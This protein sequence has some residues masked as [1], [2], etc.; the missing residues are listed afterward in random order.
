MALSYSCLSRVCVR[1]TIAVIISFLYFLPLS[2][3]ICNRVS[4]HDFEESSFAQG[5]LASDGVNGAPSGLSRTDS[6]VIS[7][8]YAAKLRVLGMGA[9]MNNRPMRFALQAGKYYTLSFWT[10]ASD[11]AKV[12][13]GILKD[14]TFFPA[15]FDSTE[16]AFGWQEN[17]VEF[18]APA[19]WP[20][21]VLVFSPEFDAARGPY[22]L[23][24]DF[25]TLCEREQTNT[26]NLSVLPGFESLAYT[27]AWSHYD[28]GAP[29]SSFLFLESE[30]VYAGRFSSKMQ[31]NSFGGS[32]SFLTTHSRAFFEV[33]SGSYYTFS[34]WMKSDVDSARVR[35]MVNRRTPY[36]EYNTE[37]FVLDKV[38]RKYSMSFQA[39]ESAPQAYVRFIAKNAYL[40]QPYS[41]LIDD[42]RL[43]KTNEPPAVAPGGVSRGLIFWTKGNDGPSARVVNDWEDKSPSGNNLQASGTSPLRQIDKVNQNETVNFNSA[44]DRMVSAALP[45]D[46]RVNAHAWFV[47]LKGNNPTQGAAPVAFW[48]NGY[49]LETDASNQY[50]IS[51]IK[52]PLTTSIPADANSWN[53]LSI[54]SNANDYRIFVNGRFF[55]A[56]PALTGLDLGDST[57]LG[58]QALDNTNWYN[59]DIAEV[60]V[61]RN[62][63]NAEERRRVNTYLSLKYGI[64]IPVGQ[65]SFY[66]YTSHPAALAGIGQDRERMEFVQTK[67][68]NVQAGSIVSISRPTRM[69]DGDF[70]VWG[71]NNASLNNSTQVPAGVL[72]RLTRTWR[73]SHTGDLGKVTVS[74]DL[75]ELG[76]TPG[77]GY[78]LLVDKDG[79][80]SNAVSY[81]NPYINDNEIGFP[82]VR[83]EE[84]DYFTLGKINNGQAPQAPGLV[85]DGLSLWLQAGEGPNSN[86]LS[87]WQDLSRLSN[88]ASAFD[89]GPRREPDQINGNPAVDFTQFRNR[90]IGASDLYL[91][92][93]GHSYYI[94]LNS[95]GTRNWTNPFTPRENGYRLEINGNTRNYS[96]YG[97]EPGGFNSSAA[98]AEWSMIGV[99][100]RQDQYEFYRNGELNISRSVRDGLVGEGPYFV[101]SRNR[102]GGGWFTG[103]IAELI[104]Y[105]KEQNSQDRNAVETY[106][107]IKYGLPIPTSSHLYY[108]HDSHPN[109]LAG[110]GRDI[111][112][113]L[114]QDNSKSLDETALVRISNPSGLGEGEY[115]VWGHD[116]DTLDR[117]SNVPANVNER[118]T[119][120]WKVSRT[121]NPG[122]VWVEF[123][124]AG[125]G[126]DLSDASDF[127]LLIDT[128]QDFSDATVRNNGA[129]LGSSLVF[130][131][132]QFQDGNTFSLATS[133]LATSAEEEL[134]SDLLS[135]KIFPNPGNTFMNLEFE[136]RLPTQLNLTIYDFQGRKLF[137]KD[138]QSYA[139]TQDLQINTTQ[140]PQGMY[141][142]R[143][144]EGPV[145]ISRTW[146]KQ[147]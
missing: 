93:A 103:K 22:D 25:I 116:G 17:I 48:E 2:G 65:H 108:S 72:S 92:P 57:I 75:S 96:V 102:F 42:I 120:T 111:Q 47:V 78:T 104:V 105:A 135:W 5:W 41:I 147:P 23:F 137:E 84:G 39:T 20:Y 24:L 54:N 35:T 87:F 26:C 9:S 64:T 66:P 145:S 45:I 71:H 94:V 129:L 34:C 131:G 95:A 33:D 110:I 98:S 53:I 138:I 140:W 27:T 38:W 122:S 90:M 134:P 143:L 127:S 43:C 109:A 118:F 76:E 125:L 107:S 28:G 128:D 123:E 60:I 30:D 80:F 70:L 67:S 31:I 68:R 121:G 36:K 1:N 55:Q 114:W 117:I 91:S 86:S 58:A 3:Q 61:F 119:R 89:E 16:V 14:S 7:G 77:Y 106:L 142:I 124:L 37:Y 62:G 6:A 52:P 56:G 11:S 146:L 63:L 12:K 51:G 74:F 40:T 18:Q 79:N 115:L 13:F 81:G 19:D 10:R 112:Q 83:L 144:S 88:S 133:D 82:G 49:R 113:R 97:L 73:V 8:D 85:D 126:L 136:T 101:G 50:M 59:G 99:S 44:N 21:S 69:D 46:N 100:A 32:G 130:K 29:G 15:L 141:F 4:H 132:V 139:A